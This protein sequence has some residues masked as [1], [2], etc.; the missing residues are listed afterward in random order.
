MVLIGCSGENSESI[1]V[2]SEGS[3]V[4][5]VSESEGNVLPAKL[6]QIDFG[7]RS[8]CIKVDAGDFVALTLTDGTELS[9]PRSWLQTVKIKNSKG[10]KTT[11]TLTDVTEI[12]LHL[13]YSETE[14]ECGVIIPILL[15]AIA[16][17]LPKDF[18]KSP[19][20][21]AYYSPNFTVNKKLHHDVAKMFSGNWAESAQ[22]ESVNMRWPNSTEIIKNNDVFTNRTKILTKSPVNAND[23]DLVYNGFFGQYCT[24]LNSNKNCGFFEHSTWIET[25]RKKT[26]LILYK[27]IN[28]NYEWVAKIETDPDMFHKGARSGLHHEKP[29]TSWLHFKYIIPK[30][31]IQIVLSRIDHFKID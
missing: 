4:A 1:E 21:H 20:A 26:H 17:P 30:Q 31:S 12:Q 9:L 27:P 10:G 14:K 19:E 8:D 3:P 5:P 18:I 29:T 28:L 25:Q 16:Q 23:A 24:N 2:Q 22:Y 6:H 13:P 15:H 7:N 11:S